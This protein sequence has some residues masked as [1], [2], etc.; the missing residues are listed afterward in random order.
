VVG[1]VKHQKKLWI[2]GVIAMVVSLVTGIAVAGLMFALSG[3]S[4]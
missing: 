3:R 2:I 1:L 4:P